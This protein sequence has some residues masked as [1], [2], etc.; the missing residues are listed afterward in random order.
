MARL[1]GV[2]ELFKG[3][4]GW[5]RGTR[6]LSTNGAQAAGVDE[7]LKEKQESVKLRVDH[8]VRV[9]LITVVNICDC[10]QTR[11]VGVTGD[12]SPNL[13]GLSCVLV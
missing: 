3:L 5:A 8:Q 13:N 7:A 9:A 6:G 4:R 1:V 12:R 11:C 10:V 2:D